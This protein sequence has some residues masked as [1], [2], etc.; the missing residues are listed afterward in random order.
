LE[1]ENEGKFRPL[2]HQYLA[3]AEAHLAAGWNYTNAL[4]RG[5]VRVRLA[6]A[7]PVLIGMKTL[8]KLRQGNILD[9]RKPIK[10]SRLE[11]KNLLLR[12]ILY[13]PFPAVWR[14]L[15]PAPGQDRESS[16]VSKNI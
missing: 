7:W 4:P 6:C 3:Q 12:S 14:G 16:C 13:Y 1:P 9:P 8:A 15:F 11:V 5:C 10:I 2:F